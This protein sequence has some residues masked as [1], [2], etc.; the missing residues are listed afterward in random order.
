MSDQLLEEVKNYLDITWDMDAGERMKLSGI[1]VR[2][3]NYLRGKIGDCDF[4]EDTPEKELLMNYVM[5]VRA[6][7]LSDFVTNYMREIIALQMN[8][9]RSRKNAES[10]GKRVYLL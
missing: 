4:E 9:W 10:E 5:Y 2:G 8:R 3:E 1:V 6:G 7:R